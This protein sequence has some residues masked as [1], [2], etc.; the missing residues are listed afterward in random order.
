VLVG[1][2]VGHASRSRCDRQ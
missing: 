1:T 2:L